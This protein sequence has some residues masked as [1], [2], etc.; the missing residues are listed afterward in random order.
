[1][2]VSLIVV[3]RF[4]T[5][6]VGILTVIFTEM[7]KPSLKFMWNCKNKQANKIPQTQIGEKQSLQRIELEDLTLHNSESCYRITV[8]KTVC[9]SIGIDI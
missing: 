9:T 6:P 8:M 3:Y 7:E 1:M 2:S 5:I 4:R